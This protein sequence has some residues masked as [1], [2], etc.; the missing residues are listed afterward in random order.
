MNRSAVLAL[1]TVPVLLLATISVYLPGWATQQDPAIIKKTFLQK[2]A[3]GQQAE[4][5]LG[6]LAKTKA[7]SDSV[8]QF[9]E[10][11]IEDHMKANQ[12]VLQLAAKEGIQIPTEMNQT[13]KEKHQELLHLSGKDFDQ[14]YM[15]YMLVDHIKDVQE[16]KQSAE[17]LQDPQLRQWASGTLPLL[18]HHLQSAKTVGSAVGVAASD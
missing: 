5:A 9:A 1:R 6:R 2:A 14:S 8:K 11:M 15:S 13:Q 7:S 4:I 10:R 12:E 17:M 16:F 3:Q 18:E